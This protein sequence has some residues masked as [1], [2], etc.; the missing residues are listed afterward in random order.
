MNE[1]LEIYERLRAEYDRGGMT[2]L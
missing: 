1:N 2:M